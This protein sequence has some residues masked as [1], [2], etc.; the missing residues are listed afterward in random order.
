MFLTVFTK[1][2][3]VTDRLFFTTAA[4][5]ATGFAF[6]GKRL[7]DSMSRR[8]PSMQP[9]RLVVVAVRMIAALVAV[10]EFME[11]RKTF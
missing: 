10:A 8:V 5:A 7:V 3:T 1:S 6:G 2:S 11:L 9:S 4:V